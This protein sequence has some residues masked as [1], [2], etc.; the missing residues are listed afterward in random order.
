[1]RAAQDEVDKKRQVEKAEEER[2]MQQMVEDEAKR[3]ESLRK[4]RES[5]DVTA[6]VKQSYN[7]NDV[8]FDQ[9]TILEQFSSHRSSFRVV[10]LVREIGRG[11]LT[12]VFEARVKQTPSGGHARYVARPTSPLMTAVMTC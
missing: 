12:S 10:T 11:P 7:A 4:K 2:M 8:V 3:R 9:E 6:V 1:M 5:H